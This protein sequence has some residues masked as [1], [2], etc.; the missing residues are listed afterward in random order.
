MDVHPVLHTRYERL[1]ATAEE[2]RSIQEQVK[3]LGRQKRRQWQRIFNVEDEIMTECDGLI[4]KLEKMK[5]RTE[6]EP[7]F[8]IPWGV[9]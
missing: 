7:L 4:E 5:Q 8:T 9:V 6:V 1:D 2:Q 3:D